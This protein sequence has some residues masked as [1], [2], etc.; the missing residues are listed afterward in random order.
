MRIQIAPLAL[1]AIRFAA[2]E[3]YPHECI[4]GLVGHYVAPDQWEV[5]LAV[6]YQVA[7]RKRAS[8]TAPGSSKLAEDFWGD[9]MVGE[10]HSHPC[11]VPTLSK[12]APLCDFEEMEEGAIE[13]IAAIWPGKR[14]WNVRFRAY[15]RLGDRLHRR[16]KLEVQ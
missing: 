7:K 2:I 10:F 3:T 12:G 8:V 16:V 13:I 9:Q 1:R 4:G 14:D 5:D 11:E 6:P 15:A